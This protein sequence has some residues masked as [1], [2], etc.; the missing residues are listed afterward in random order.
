MSDRLGALDESQLT[1]DREIRLKLSGEAWFDH[2]LIA[3]F[4]SF[5]AGLLLIFTVATA[6]GFGKGTVPPPLT[7][8]MT[9]L[10][11]LAWWAKRRELRFRRF[12]TEGESISN[13]NAVR[14]LAESRRWE[15]LQD[16][17]AALL[18]IRTPMSLLSW[19]ELLTVRFIGSEVF[20]NCIP[21][22]E[23]RCGFAGM[24]PASE[25]VEAV[26][27]TLGASKP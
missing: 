19:G 14:A 3:L 17:E 9:G 6:F 25:R 12:L 18:Q 20:V 21:F 1:S 26:V 23:G 5:V 2:T 7:L 13:C 4:A 15:I 8:G 10:T 22:P 11:V 16:D 24:T 27:S